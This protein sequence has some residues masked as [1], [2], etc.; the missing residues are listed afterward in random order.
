MNFTWRGEEFC[1]DFVPLRA[2]SSTPPIPDCT[3]RCDAFRALDQRIN[4]ENFLSSFQALDDPLAGPELKVVSGELK[5]PS[6]RTG[7]EPVLTLAVT[8]RAY[9]VE[10]LERAGWIVSGRSG[11]AAQLGMDERPSSIA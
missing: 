7:P 2:G 4:D 8:E 9:I 6:R 11:A 3:A 10:E 5:L 1:T